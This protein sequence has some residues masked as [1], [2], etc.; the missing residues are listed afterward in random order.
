MSPK[1]LMEEVPLA[2]V[3]VTRTLPAAPAGEVTSTSE[4]NTLVIAV[5][6]LAPKCTAVVP[7]RLMP[8]MCTRVPPADGKGV[9][10]GQRAAGWAREVNMS[11][12][13]LEEGGSLAVG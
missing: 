13:P 7:D 3:T 8:R 4:D 6:R 2:V 1:P 9:G 5:P 12:K 11:A 10:Q